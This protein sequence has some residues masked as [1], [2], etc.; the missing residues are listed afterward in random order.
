MPVTS[1]SKKQQDER[2]QEQNPYM[3]VDKSVTKSSDIYSFAVIARAL[4]SSKHPKRSAEKIQYDF[5]KEINSSLTSLLKRCLHENPQERPT[6]ATIVEALEVL[7]AESSDAITDEVIKNANDKMAQLS[8]KDNSGNSNKSLLSKFTSSKK[9]RFLKRAPP[10]KTS[11]KDA[12]S[13]ANADQETMTTSQRKRLLRFKRPKR[14]KNKYAANK[15]M[16]PETPEEGNGSTTQIFNESDE[17]EVMSTGTDTS[18]ESM[19]SIERG[20]PPYKKH[21]FFR[22]SYAPEPRAGMV[23]PQGVQI[24]H[25]HVASGVPL[26]QP[27]LLA[28]NSGPPIPK[29]IDKHYNINP[30]GDVSAMFF[31][32][33]NPASKIQE[34]PI[35]KL[36]RHD[37]EPHS[38]S[39]KGTVHRRASSANN[40]VIGRSTVLEY[41]PSIA[42]PVLNPPFPTMNSMQNHKFLTYNV[43]AKNVD[44]SPVLST[45]LETQDP[46]PMPVSSNERTYLKDL[47]ESDTNK[48][49][50]A[51]TLCSD[52][53]GISM[54]VLGG[55]LSNPTVHQEPL[56]SSSDS[57]T[58]R[59][60]IDV[61]M[62]TSNVMQ[63]SNEDNNS[64]SIV[65]DDD[66]RLDA[67]AILYSQFSAQRSD[68]PPLPPRK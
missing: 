2:E 18:T 44:P 56:S 53:P 4:I 11:K 42:T 9:N 40:F 13:Y 61:E 28:N 30:D 54:P 34:R 16:L 66:A 33:H 29:S 20:A 25:S 45:I 64:I 15:S 60:S 50:M 23:V 1:C 52:I 47:S 32:D 49:T 3:S 58:T 26:V 63:A 36:R 35:M 57:E 68:K 37:S 27:T 24:E 38:L 12:S 14:S 46:F 41:V 5:P 8:M 7:S 17:E 51:P 48:I 19:T 43:H 21:A 22:Y 31:F 67:A 59:S 10:L 65:D 6:F 39:E 55:P 62:P